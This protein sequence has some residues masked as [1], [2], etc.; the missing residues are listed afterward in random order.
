MKGSFPR[1]RAVFNPNRKNDTKYGGA[2]VLKRAW[3]YLNCNDLL[4]SSGIQKR[5]GVPANCL[6]FNYVLKPLMDA[7]SISRTNSRTRSDELLKT[8]IP[9]HNQCTLNRFLNGDYNWNLLNEHRILELQKRNRTRALEDGLIVLDDVVIQKS[10]EMMENIAY[11]WDPID[12]K[13]VLGYNAVVLLYTDKEKRHPLNFAF[14]L[15]ENDKISLA[16]HLVERLRELKI[17]TKHMVFDSWYFALDLINVLRDLKFFWVTKSKKNRLFIL[18]GAEV[19]AEE[20]IQSGIKEALAQLPG[21]GHVKVVVVEINEE[22]RLLVTSDLEMERKKVI[23]TYGDR[24][25]IDNPFFRDEKQE[26]GLADFHTR[27]LNAL[28]AHTALCFL[29]HTLTSLVKLFHKNL[30]DKTI[31]WI[32]ENLFKAVA[33]VK[34][35]EEGIRVTFGKGLELLSSLSSH[36]I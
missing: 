23:K 11:V 24:F 17:K 35:V 8:L 12:K 13:A 9:D 2:V 28:V 32:K 19:H 26:M 25:E 1:L 22:K 6:T 27:R 14:K 30:C 33:G 3:D 34:R 16:I 10:G 21:Y 29:S 31:G 18:N 7:G 36:I 20:I 5:S 15:E 4:L